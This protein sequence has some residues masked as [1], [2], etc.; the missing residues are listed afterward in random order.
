MTKTPPS[1]PKVLA[2]MLDK[3]ISMA[4]DEK[5]LSFADLVKATGLDPARDFVG[6]SLRNLDF[7]DEDLRAFNFSE[8]DLTGADFRRANVAGVRFARS[9][10]TGAIGLPDE[11]ALAVEAAVDAAPAVQEK[12]LTAQQWFERALAAVDIDERLRF[13]TEAIRLEPDYANAFNNRSS[14]RRDKGDLDGA[15]QDSTEAI[16]LKSDHALAFINRGN[17]R[18]GKGDLD[19]ALQD[20]DEGHPAPAG[21]CQRLLQPGTPPR[22]RLLR[23]S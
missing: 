10:L 17:A 4:S 19:G 20:F 5:Q 12:E 11:M 23:S 13:Y 8:A 2:D 1:D 7:R 18:S 3:L 6:A 22:P 15:L 16:R 21:L 14:V 9:N